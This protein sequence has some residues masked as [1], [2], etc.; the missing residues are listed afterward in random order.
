MNITWKA[1]LK[2]RDKGGKEVKITSMPRN[3]N[4]KDLHLVGKSYGVIRLGSDPPHWSSDG[5]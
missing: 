3:G 1:T 5:K 4:N 2:V